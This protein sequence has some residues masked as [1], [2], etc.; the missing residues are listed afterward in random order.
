[1]IDFANINRAALNA[2]PALLLRWLPD[3]R[4]RGHEYVARNPTRD[5]RRP[6]SF[7]INMRTGCWADFADHARGGDV[8]SLYAYLRGVRQGEAACELARVLGI[9][10]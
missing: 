1:M 6:G 7:S 3:G 10:S 9:D 4:R 8:I 5:D 2:L